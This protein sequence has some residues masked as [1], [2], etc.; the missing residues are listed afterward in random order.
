LEESL[1]VLLFFYAHTSPPSING[2]G[3]AKCDGLEKAKCTLKY[4]PWRRKDVTE[5]SNPLCPRASRHFNTHRLKITLKV[6]SKP[7]S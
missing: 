1:T 4:S 6:E 5:H 2:L 3:S 7:L